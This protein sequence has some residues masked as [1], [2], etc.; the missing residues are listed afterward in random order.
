M[1][2]TDNNGLSKEIKSG[3]SVTETLVLSTTLDTTS[4][5]ADLEYKN[6]TEILEYTNTEGSFST[7]F[8]PGNQESNPEAEN[9]RITEPDSYIAERLTILGPDGANESNTIYI[10][11]GT[12]LAVLAAGIVIIKVFVLKR[13]D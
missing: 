13:K 8:I 11:I 9:F 10:V 4:G 12:S 3:E 6:I 7:R 1:V 2:S 5:N